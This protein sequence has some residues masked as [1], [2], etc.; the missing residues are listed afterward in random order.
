MSEEKNVNTTIVDGIEVLD[1]AELMEKY[2]RE[3]KYRHLEGVARGI[4]FAIGVAWSIFHLYTGLFGVFPSTLQRAPH[5]AAAMVLAYL[6]YPIK[7]KAG[8]TIPIWDW[9]LCGLSFF[10]GAYHVINY[11]ALLL[12]AGLYTQMDMIVSIIAIL[13]LL[14]AARRV[15]GPIIVC[16]AGFFLVYAVLGQ[17]VPGFLAHGGLSLKRVVCFE[18]L[19]T[20]G[21][22]GTPIYVSSSFI[23]LFLI[24]ATFLKNSGVGDWMTGMAMGACGGAAGGPAKA[25]V[26]ASALEGTVSGSS[27]ANTV[28]SGSITIPLM[29]KT[30]YKPEFAGAVEAAASTGGQIMP[31]IMGAAAFIMTEY[32]GV[33]YNTIAFAAVIPAILYFTGI[34]ANVH[35][36]AMRKGLLGV[37]KE[38]R[39]SVSHLLKT[40]WYKIAP[41]LIIIFLLGS[42]RSV[43]YSALFGILSCM[44]IWVINIF[45]SGEKFNL[46]EFAK[47]FILSLE[48]TA[49]GAIS[50]V[51]ACGCAGIIVGSITMTGLG[52]KLAGGIV[53]LSGGLL[54]PTLVLTMLCCIFLGL[55]LPTTA[56][57]IIQA[58]ITAPALVE[59]GIP[60]LAAHMFVFYFGIVADITPLVGLAAIAGA[61]IAGASTIK[62]GLNASRLGISAYVAP[63][64]FVLNPVLLLINTGDWSTPMFVLMIIEAAALTIIGMVCIAMGLSGYCLMPC[65]WI[66][67]IILIAGGIFMVM[68]STW[69]DI[70]GIAILVAMIVQQ[71]VRKGRDAI[72]ASS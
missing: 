55:G 37:P 25:A 39:P 2:D 67:R 65:N 72:P 36:E 57:Y 10:C 4:V 61:G 21:I 45:A 23:Y 27:V 53:D 26:I 29:K 40:G 66:E 71:K 32:V 68:P 14:E 56:N 46:K 17:Y 59:L 8:K 16:L 52:L 12:R 9:I 31:P 47:M 58:T 41:L 15:V 62:T 69:S 43:M 70:V 20:E 34:Y 7:G 28:G 19:G 50:V 3:S 30:G 6:L 24:F 38:Q 18:F 33:P 48:E 54:M 35:F 1:E 63:Y 5:L 13:L 49:R 42:G 44:V 51:L 64:I 60:A 22:L 11:E